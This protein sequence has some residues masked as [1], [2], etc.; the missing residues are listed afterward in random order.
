MEKDL[1][2]PDSMAS[3]TIKPDYPPSEVY[4][5]EP[6]PAYHRPKSVSVQVAKIIAVTVI[7]VSVVLGGCILASAYITA[8][9]SCRHLEQELQLLTESMD[10]Y[11]PLQPEALVQ[12]EPKHIEPLEAEETKAPV[13]KETPEENNKE[14]QDSS[15]ESSESSSS[16][17]SSDEEDRI[18]IQIKLPLHLDFDDLA[19]TMMDKNQRSKMNC[20]VEKKKAEEVVDHKAKTV[21]L[22]FGVN[23]TTDP[24]YERLSGERIAIFCESGNF[25][26]IEQPQ[27]QE[28]EEE[29]TIMIQPVMIP[30]PAA[31]FHTHM[32]MQQKPMHPMETMR[33][34]MPIPMMQQQH[35]QQHEQQQQPQPQGQLPP[36]QI[37]HHIAQQI[38]AQ[39]LQ[40]EAQRAQ[41]EVQTNEVRPDADQQSNEQRIQI[42]Q[43]LA[44]LPI[45]EEILSQLDRLPN[46]DVIVV[47]HH[48]SEETPQDMRLMQHQRDS[49]QGMNGRQ[50]FARSVMPINIPVPMM[51]QEPDVRASEEPREH[52]LH[53]RSIRSVE[54]F[55][56]KSQKRVKRCACDCVC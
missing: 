46:R 19:G 52:Y 47:S 2:P 43:R 6:P 24:R 26:R 55:V 32:P 53:P 22:P 29:Q 33:P 36:N 49:A 31:Q 3:V 11:Q 1:A 50:S 41:E 9:A 18:P 51:R 4:S 30:L 14:S 37:L 7:L 13:V 17:D 15:D 27:Q 5:S 10:R 12:D 42:Q 21:S 34:P 20:V 54:D 25:Q 45:P 16:E 40:Q 28:Q 35:Q 23:I 48:E 56:P 38:I 44:R 39:K 8:N